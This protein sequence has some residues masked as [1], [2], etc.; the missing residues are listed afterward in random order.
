MIPL[1]VPKISSKEWEYVK[2]CLDEGWV[3]SV[4]Q[5][6]DRFENEICKYTKAKF[7]VACTNGTAAL[8][9]A[10]KLVGVS[11]GDE[12][13]V[14]TLT[15]IATVNAVRYLD[16]IPV[17]MDCDNYFNIDIEKTI[18]FLNKETITIKGKTINKRTKRIIKA[19]IPVHVFGNAADLDKLLPIC[20]KKNIKIIEDSTESLGSFY[21]KGPLKERFTGTIGAIGCF[22]FNG[23]K[24]ITTGGGG[25]LVTNN[26]KYAKKAK[27]LS[28]QAKDDPIKFIHNEIGYN[29]RLTNIQAAMGVAQ[30]EK[31]PNFIKIKKS[32]YNKYKE[33]IDN[34]DG[35][36]IANVPPYANNNTW[37][38][39][40][41]I[42]KNKLKKNRDELMLY[43]RKNEIGVR[44]IW[45][46]NHM[47]KPFKKYQAYK[48]EKAYEM[49]SKTINIP[50]S[51]GLAEKEIKTVI[52]YL[53]IAYRKA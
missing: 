48:I 35:L 23:N 39:A 10:L 2:A 32:N 52:K 37:L 24:I 8:Q 14:P 34:I 4:G 16:G 12:V 51:V 21:L 30:L 41:I 7:A 6:V 11:A 50:S 5:F 9:L 36:N 38:Y 45:Y 46:L 17:F 19:I 27:Y 18:R 26:E 47:Q 3:S 49:Y 42:D 31:L 40:L 43:L 22:S 28:T 29:F 33:F 25:M 13:I 20:Q 15:F 1:S 53:K 44:P